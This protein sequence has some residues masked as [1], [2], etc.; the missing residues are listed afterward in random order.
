MPY[1]AKVSNAGGM[2]TV[3]RYTDML[4]GNATWNPWEPAG[5]Y[6]SIAAVTVGPTAV[7][8][9]T[10]NSIPAT[11]QHL[12][13]RVFS[14]S[15]ATY[16]DMNFNSDF[17]NN[18]S[19]HQVLGD[20]SSVSSAG[21]AS[22]N[23]IYANQLGGSTTFPSV[24]IIDILDYSNTSK[25]KTVRLLSGLDSNGGGFIYYRTGAWFNTAAIS[26]IRLAAQSGTSTFAQNTHI[27]LY[28]VKG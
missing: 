19:Y 22:M 27:A 28:G 2:S 3:T 6:E 20:G 21:S 4:A 7:A 14:I 8:N 23:V 11:F 13:L 16:S 26:S 9:V 18:Y 5:A 24:G 15:A 1:V 25:N 12:Q 17:N 10:F